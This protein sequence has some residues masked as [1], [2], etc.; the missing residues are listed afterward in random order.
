MWC[1]G[2]CEHSTPCGLFITIKAWAWYGHD[3]PRTLNT[4]PSG[5]SSS[6]GS[7]CTW[8]PMLTWPDAIR[9]SHSRRAPKPWEKRICESFMKHSPF[10]L[11][12]RSRERTG[13]HYLCASVQLQQHH[14]VVGNRPGDAGDALAVE[15]AD[16]R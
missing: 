14:V 13:P 5:G 2:F 11:G 1:L 9:P 6:N 4:R 10:G 15:F 12:Y 7:S 3:S 8:P 16:H